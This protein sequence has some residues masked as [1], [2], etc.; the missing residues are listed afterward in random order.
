MTFGA[1]SKRVPASG[2]PDVYAREAFG[3]FAGLLNA[4]SYWITAGAGN[5][6]IVL[7]WVGCV[8]VFVNTGHKTA[9]SIGIALIGL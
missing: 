1:L 6:A 2:G 3:E 8:E 7:A 9:I 4:W 5:A